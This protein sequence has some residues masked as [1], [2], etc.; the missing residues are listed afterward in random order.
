MEKCPTTA[1]PFPIKHRSPMLT[2]GSVMQICPGI[3][4]A[5]NVQ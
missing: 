4:P 3:I 5:D 1:L 2:T